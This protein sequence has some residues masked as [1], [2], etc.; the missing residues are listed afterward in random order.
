MN[1]EDINY[2]QAHVLAEARMAVGEAI[3]RQHLEFKERIKELEAEVAELRERLFTMTE[4][5][6]KLTPITKS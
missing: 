1:A 3:E 4:A 6:V 2:N 5:K